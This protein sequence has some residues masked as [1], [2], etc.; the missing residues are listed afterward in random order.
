MVGAPRFSK[1]ASQGV[2]CR[3]FLTSMACSPST[4][5]HVDGGH[6]R[7][8]GTTS[9]GACHQY[10][11]ALMVG[12]PGSSGTASQGGHH[13]CF[14]ALMVGAPRSSAPSP[15]GLPSMFLSVDGGRS[16]ILS[17]HLLGGPPSM[18][19]SVD[20]GCSQ[21]LRHR[22]P[23]GRHRCFFML[24]VDAPGSSSSPPKGPTIDVSKR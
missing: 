6:S 7:I 17:H 23:G 1:T 5:L 11:S 8:S 10:F 19:L 24:M 13:R 2:C 9:Q 20:G 12:T 3:R 16:R 14:L 15:R 22:L 18:F 21:I 4:F